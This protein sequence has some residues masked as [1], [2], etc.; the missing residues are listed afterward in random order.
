MSQHKPYSRYKP[1][2]VEWIGEIPEWWNVG[3]IKQVFKVLNGSTPK[4]TNS[5]FW[6]GDICWATPDDL[7][8]INT[9]GYLC[10][11]R[12]KITKDGYQSCGSTL[13]AKNSLIISTRAP[14][15]Y[16][17]VMTKTMCCNQ[18]CRI[19]EDRD[20]KHEKRYYYYFLKSAN[21]E[22]NNLGEGTTFK[23]L[24][25]NK[26]TGFNLLCFS[27]Y[28]QKQIANFLDKKT[29]QIDELIDKKEKM[30]KLLKEKRSAIIN[31]AVT[32]G[33]DSNAKMKPSG[34][35]WIGDIP[36]GWEVKKLKHV[37]SLCY[38]NS[39]S[40]EDRVEGSVPVYGSNGS[41]DFHNVSIT[42]SPCIIVG[43]KG[44]YGKIN[45]SVER[46]FPID[47]TYY[48]DK[49]FTKTCMKWLY[50]MLPLLELDK[51]SQ[52]TGVPGLSR[53]Y[54]YNK[55]I[56]LPNTLEQQQI[57]NFLDKKIKNIDKLIQ[58]VNNAIEKLHEYRSAIIT[59][60]VT[61]K[62]DVRGKISG[63]AAIYGARNNKIIGKEKGAM[64]GRGAMNRARTRMYE[65]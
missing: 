46:C 47:T 41:V 52:D 21:R 13:S 26:L 30:L 43:R 18:G 45:Y 24:S 61:G 22:L 44:S 35:D 14:I 40:A 49:R 34:I 20:E 12:R 63:G 36:E 48:I 9:N 59:A 58:G 11:T 50:Y 8:K 38:G 64:N 15:G 60:T 29:A 3:K 6:D 54:A 31:Q 42:E 57:A 39:L 1:S 37:A 17:A 55:N 56:C 33:I 4:S 51:F 27:I 25:R 2:G 19:L 10:D 7:S 5:D 23:E 53:E 65:E 32:K 62:I 16:V 28:E